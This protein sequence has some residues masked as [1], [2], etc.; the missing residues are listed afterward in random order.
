[1]PTGID[2][3][4]LVLLH[5]FGDSPQCWAPFVRAL[6]ERVTVAVTLPAAPGHAGLPPAPKGLVLQ[7][8]ADHAAEHVRRTAEAAGRPVVLGGHSMG[9]AT[10]TAI[11]AAHPDL[12]AGLFCEDPPWGWPPSDAP[13][14]TVDVVNAQ[15]R[16]WILG[17]QS[18]DHA[19]RV[20]WCHDHN[21]G[22]PQ[23]E[24][25]P[26]ARSKA[27]VHPGAFDPPL[28]IGRFR[29]QPIAHAVRCPAALV[30]GDPAHG[31]V[32]APEA[33]DD[34]AA[35][36]TWTVTRLPGVGHDVRRQAREATLTALTDLL[37]RVDEAPVY[38]A[39]AARP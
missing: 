28:D 35:G 1:M 12:V 27:D 30:V 26:W 13:D 21:P 17:L 18:G 15:Y 8:L 5:G 4:P 36:T 7:A 22:W 31:S 2:T 3:N 14:R 39:R 23:D 37:A 20:R 9:A 25:D 29:W 19:S 32:T 10:A 33:A 16:E 6:R 34:L 38:A 24:Y 11:A